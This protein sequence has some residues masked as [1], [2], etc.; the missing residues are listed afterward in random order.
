MTNH[1]QV[2]LESALLH[3]SKGLE[4][5]DDLGLKSIKDRI[6]QPVLDLDGYISLTN[7]ENILKLIKDHWYPDPADP[8]Y[9]RDT[10][11]GSVE[12]AIAFALVKQLLLQLHKSGTMKEY[13]ENENDL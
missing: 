6:E 12:D 10:A 1:V 11:E 4:I 2:K 3:F 5:L 8:N 7:P 9:D 13:K